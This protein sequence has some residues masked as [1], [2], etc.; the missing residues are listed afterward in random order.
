MMDIIIILSFILSGL[1]ILITVLTAMFQIKEHK[2][3]MK[4]LKEDQAL[5]EDH[6]KLYERLWSEYNK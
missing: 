6:Q 3:H 4:N 1:A 2:N 5:L